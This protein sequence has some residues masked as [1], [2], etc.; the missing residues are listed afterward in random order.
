MKSVAESYRLGF[1]TIRII[2]AETCRAIWN[3]LGPDVLA[4][5]T[6]EQWRQHALDFEQ[7]WHFPNCVGAVD[8]KHVMMEKPINSGS[9]NYNYKG[10]CSIVL[11]TVVDAKYRFVY[12]SVG[13]NGQESDGGVWAACD[14]GQKLE[15]QQ[16]G[17]TQVLPG[18]EPLPGSAEVMPHVLVG[19]EAFPLREHLMRPFPGAALNTDER[20]VY[21]YR[22]CRARRTV[23]NAYGI[24]AQRW[25][26]YRGPIGCSVA[27]T[28]L[29]VQ[30]TCVLHN[31][32]REKEIAR[33]GPGAYS[34]VRLEERGEVAGLRQVT[35][36]GATHNHPQRAARLRERFV[37]YFSGAGNVHWQMDKIRR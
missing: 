16:N 22:L 4:L 29:I 17:G 21:N 1:A 5:P 24:M 33:G 7:E 12:I 31:V 8:G 28:K 36:V 25:R 34:N 10:Y 6:P 30:A 23:E 2:I 18:P 14:L 37:E 32:L 26:V 27:T 13:A 19:D 11:M 15:A 20:R 9:I 3:V 35:D